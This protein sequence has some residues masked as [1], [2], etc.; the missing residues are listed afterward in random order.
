MTAPTTTTKPI[1]TLGTMH[2]FKD[3]GWVHEKD[4]ITRCVKVVKNQMMMK[5]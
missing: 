2:L 4:L 1:K 5:F 3:I